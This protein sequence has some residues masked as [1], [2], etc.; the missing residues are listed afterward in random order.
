MKTKSKY[1]AKWGL[2]LLTTSLERSRKMALTIVTLVQI[3]YRTAHCHS[4]VLTIYQVGFFGTVIL[5]MKTQ[6][7]LGVLAIPSALQVLGMV[8]GVVCLVI[9]G[10]MTTWSGWM[11]GRFKLNHREMYSIDDAGAIMWGTT[12]RVICATAFCLCMCSRCPSLKGGG[13]CKSNH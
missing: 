7:G 13:G 10:A 6:I 9:I 1:L 5:M 11:I 2:L 8:P 3:V 12:G 4:K